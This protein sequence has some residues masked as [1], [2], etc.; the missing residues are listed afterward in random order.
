[1]FLLTEEQRTQM[2][3]NGAARTRGEHTDPYPVLKLYTPDGGLS[4]VLSELDVDG[5]LAY[6]LIDVGT[7]FP[8]LGL[9]SLSMLASIKGPRGMSVVA[10][11][12]YK[13]RKTLS[14]YL[15]ARRA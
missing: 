12:H 11:P 13:A 6:G 5:D 10:E 9:V 2:L 4:W 8:E 15:G 7:G 1:M 3:S 14:A